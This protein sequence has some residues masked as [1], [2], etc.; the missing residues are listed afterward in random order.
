MYWDFS[1]FHKVSFPTVDV[2][3]AVCVVSSLVQVIG[4]FPIVSSC[5]RCR[6]ARRQ[7]QGCLAY[8]LSNYS[9]TIQ[10]NKKTSCLNSAFIY[11]YCNLPDN[12]T[13]SNESAYFLLCFQNKFEF[14]LLSS[15]EFF[16]SQKAVI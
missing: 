16:N 8:L 7:E 13:N 3:V 4:S 2:S 12:V 1:I 9:V 5:C 11:I 15:L 14:S 10:Y 6:L